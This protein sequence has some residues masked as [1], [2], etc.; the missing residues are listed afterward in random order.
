MEEESPESR[1]G[2][3]SW[4][5]HQL[6]IFLNGALSIHQKQKLNRPARDRRITRIRGLQRWDRLL[7]PLKTILRKLPET[8]SFEKA[9]EVASETERIAERSSARGDFC[10]SAR[11]KINHKHSRIKKGSARIK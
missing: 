5:T 9:K 3:G 8:P 4:S 1:K 10:A 6:A 11:S 7:I 2:D